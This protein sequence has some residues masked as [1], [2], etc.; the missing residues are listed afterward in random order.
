M[1]NA[2]LG[3]NSLYSD[4]INI[5]KI[6]IVEQNIKKYINNVTKIKKNDNFYYDKF[7]NL[8]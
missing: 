7:V 6:N 3:I 1:K 5:D 4:F 2:S 8:I